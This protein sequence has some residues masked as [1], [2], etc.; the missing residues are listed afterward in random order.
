M[1]NIYPSKPSNH[2]PK[3]EDCET[4]LKNEEILPDFLKVHSLLVIYTVNRSR[5]NN[6]SINSGYVK[7]R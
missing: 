2:L 6:S 7:K 4:V 3:H 5:R 1:K